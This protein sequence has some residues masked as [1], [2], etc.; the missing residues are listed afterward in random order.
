LNY[1]F[2]VEDNDSNEF[3]ITLALTEKNPY[4]KEKRKFFSSDLDMEKKFKIQENL[5]E[6]QVIE[7]FSFLRFTLYD[8][9]IGHIYKVFLNK[10]R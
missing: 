5:L 8:G 4:Y 7:F 9:D 2:I 6:N 3:P 10:I 1:G